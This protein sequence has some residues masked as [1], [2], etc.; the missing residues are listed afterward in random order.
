MKDRGA[1]RGDSERTRALVI[2]PYL[3]ERKRRD[4]AARVRHGRSP[5]AR[6]EE[7]RG[8]AE[9]I[10]VELVGGKIV[11]LGQ[12]RP[13]SFLGQGKVEEIASQVRDQAI[14]LVIMD[15]ALSP[16]Q[17]RNLEKAFAAK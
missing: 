3:A 13:A 4:A 7:A 1:A 17:Q 11:S 16:V 5:E 8:L 12:I 15:C 10:D 6:M 2:G 14:D 9:A